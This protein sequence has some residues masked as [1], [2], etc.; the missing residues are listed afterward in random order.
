MRNAN[1]QDVNARLYADITV[2]EAAGPLNAIYRGHFDGNGHT[3]TVRTAA[4]ERFMAPFRYV[5]NATF[6]NL[7]TAGVIKTNERDVAGLVANVL[8][9]STVNIIGCRSVAHRLTS[10]RLMMAKATMA[11]SWL[12]S[13]K[14]LPYQCATVSTTAA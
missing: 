14:T 5:G 4:N 12:K 9:G 6:I 2:S 7:H 8:E 13:T 11:A 10:A 3:L 1:G